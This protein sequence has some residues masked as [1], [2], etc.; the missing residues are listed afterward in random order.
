M[1]LSTQCFS[2]PHPRNKNSSCSFYSVHY[3][4]LLLALNLDH[5]HYSCLGGTAGN[6]T[7]ALSS[8]IHRHN[9]VRKV[10]VCIC[11]Y[12]CL[13]QMALLPEMTPYQ[14]VLC[15]MLHNVFSLLYWVCSLQD[16]QADCMHIYL[17]M[18]DYRYSRPWTIHR[19]ITWTLTIILYLPIAG[20]NTLWVFLGQIL[21]S[22]LY[23]I[24]SFRTSNKPGENQFIFLKQKEVKFQ[25]TKKNM[26][27]EK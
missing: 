19:E 2:Y 4:P 9:Q 21:C 10:P 5:L 3:F 24:W 15:K 27:K 13:P 16:C 22:S 23:K 12:L 1:H 20:I 11:M 26:I 7:S 14:C 8:S 6:R 25:Y 18:K 17:C